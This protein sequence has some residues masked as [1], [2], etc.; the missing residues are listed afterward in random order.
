MSKEKKD[1]IYD[2]QM[3]LFGSRRILGFGSDEWKVVEIPKRQANE[4][5]IKNHYSGKVTP[6]SYIHLGVFIDGFLRGVLQFGY[7]MNP[8]SGSSVV[9]HTEMDEYLE[10]SRMWID[11]D[12]GRN[13]ES[14]AISYSFKFIR[15]KYPKIKWIQ[16]FA[17]E[18]CKLMGLVYQACNFGYYGSHSNIFWELD[19]VVYH[20]SIMTNGD[21]QSVNA[22]YLRQNKYRAVKYELRQFR[23]L[24]FLDKKAKKNCLLRELPYPKHYN[25]D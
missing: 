19:D 18:R 10:L 11:D 3:T 2:D 22:R 14:M 25:N 23:Y 24:F 9:K 13:S 12:A 5:I 4:I 8:A 1:Y 16:S 15:A 7:A 21:N 17:D 6:H 20:N